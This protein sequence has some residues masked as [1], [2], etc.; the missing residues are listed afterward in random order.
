M[1]LTS[2]VW[3]RERRADQRR[4]PGIRR[5]RDRQY[6]HSHQR[7]PPQRHRSG[8][9][10]HL[11]HSTRFDRAH[12][13]HPRQQRR[14]AV[15]RQR[16]RRRHQHRDQDRRRAARPSRCAPKRGVGS[17][18]QRHRIGIGASS[19]RARGRRRC[20]PTR[21]KSDGYRVNNALDQHNGIGEIRYTTT[22]FSA[23]FNVS[24]DDQKLGLPGGRTVNPVTGVNQLVTDRT[25]TNTPFDFGNKQGANATAGFTKTPVERRRTHRRRRRAGQEA[26]G[27]LLRQRTL[28]G[29]QCQLRRHHLADLVV[30]PATE[31]QELDVRIALVDPDRHRLLRRDL[32]LQPE[33]VERQPAARRLRPLPAD[34][35]RLLAADHRDTSDHRFLVWRP[36]PANE[37][38]RARHSR[39]ERAGIFRPE[40]DRAAG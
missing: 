15:W 4:H 37:R 1:Q 7:P 32:P 22:D 16:R 6:P 24:G 30:D 39:S 25:G 11:D 18:N 33:P 28:A 10:G 8:R 29:F 38:N 20:L 5:V 34:A 9:R 13:N 2:L 21:I 23:F 26:A 19:T 17:F 14:G 31:H 3:R 35:C 40:P 36:H 12:R 27:R